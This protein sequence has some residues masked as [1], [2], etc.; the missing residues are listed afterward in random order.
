MVGSR[1]PSAGR[2]GDPRDRDFSLGRFPGASTEHPQTPACAEEA[3]ALALPRRFDWSS[4]DAKVGFGERP[5]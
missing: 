4:S 5:T 1:F 2:C 3:E